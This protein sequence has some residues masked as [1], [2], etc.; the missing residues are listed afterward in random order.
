MKQLEKKAKLNE[1]L[2]SPQSKHVLAANVN[3]LYYST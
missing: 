3:E 2:P 1:Y